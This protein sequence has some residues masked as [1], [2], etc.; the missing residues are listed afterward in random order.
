MLTKYRLSLLVPAALAAVFL[1]SSCS[2]TSDSGKTGSG[3]SAAEE[4]Q[5]VTEATD[6]G[7]SAGEHEYVSEKYGFAFSY[8]QLG[9]DDEIDGD[10]FV[11]LSYIS[12]DEASVRIKEPQFMTAEEFEEW[13]K[14]AWEEAGEDD[15]VYRRENFEL[16][17]YPA[18][19]VEYSHEVMGQTFRTIDLMALKDG[20][21]YDLIV[22]MKEEY[23]EDARQQFDV[24][25]DSFRLL[26]GEVD[27][28]E[29]WKDQL[30]EDFPYD[31]IS[32]AYVEEISYI[33]GDSGDDILVA[34]DSEATK[35]DLKAYYTE[36]MKDAED[37]DVDYWDITGIKSG[38]QIEINIEDGN[39]T[40]SKVKVDICK[41]TG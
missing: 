2:G 41:G 1:C 32:L 7:Q 34:Y 37:L 3:E 21:R 38:Y 18:L 11:E 8:N 35:E 31:V 28:S 29:V 25:V 26:E 24:V 13:M 39:L 12:G 15:I 4:T 10:E 6:S 16:D 20:Y 27:L 40:E 23:V 14:T 36:A 19:L 5:K 22:T 17:G 30:P 9:L 33:F